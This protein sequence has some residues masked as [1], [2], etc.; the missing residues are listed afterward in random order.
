MKEHNLKRTLRKQMNKKQWK[1]Q[2]EILLKHLDTAEKNLKTATDQIEELTLT[3]AA[4]DKK[5]ATFK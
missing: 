3:I 4:Y 2:R 1:E 5:I